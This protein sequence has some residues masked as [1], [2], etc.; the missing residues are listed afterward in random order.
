MINK[1]KNLEKS[2]NLSNTCK[3]NI[4]KTEGKGITFQG[5][6]GHDNQKLG[7]GI[8]TGNIDQMQNHEGISLRTQK[9]ILIK[10]KVC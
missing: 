4:Y 6:R 9:Y 1:T 8:T 7:L 5:I 3:A 10:G 2:N